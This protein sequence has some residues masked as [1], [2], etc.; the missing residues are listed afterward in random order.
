MGLDL[1]FFMSINPNTRT[2]LGTRFGVG[3]NIG[4][5]DIPQ[6]QYLGGTENLR[7]YRK[8]RFAG[9][10]MFFNNT[11]LRVRLK[12]FRTYLF[13]GSLGFLVFHDLGKVWSDNEHSERWHSGY[14]G[15]LWLSPVHR[16]VLTGTVSYSKEEELLPA[17]GFGFQF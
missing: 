3:H 6:A 14:G 2:V 10:T 16:F 1:S 7:G 5:F 15:G 17:I 9:R 11:E 4:N 8:D 13:P 12:Q